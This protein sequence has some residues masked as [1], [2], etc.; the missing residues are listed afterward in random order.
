M[1]H[2]AGRMDTDSAKFPAAG[3]SAGD[4]TGKKS[5]RFEGLAVRRGRQRARPKFKAAPGPARCR[6]HGC[7]GNRLVE[8][9]REVIRWAGVLR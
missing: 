1:I 8:P 5:Q 7:Q 2:G 9:E 3:L 6:D 4:P